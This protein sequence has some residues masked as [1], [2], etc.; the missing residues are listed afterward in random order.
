MDFDWINAHLGDDTSALRLK[1]G[2]EHA[3]DIL[4]I[5]MR[6]K[7][8]SKFSET[9]KN[10][11]RFIF[12]TSL[13]AEQ[14][15]SDLLALYHASLL[16]PGCT[17][18]DLTSGMGIDAMAFSGVAARVVAVE[19]DPVI[20]D[21]LRANARSLSNLTVVNDD[22]RNF[23]KS[24]CRF[25]VMFIDPARRNA[26]GGRV[27]ALADCEPD[28]VDLLPAVRQK[29]SSLIVK[30]SPM[31]D[32]T[33]SVGELAPY[34]ARVITLGTTTECKE[35]DLICDFNRSTANEP[36][37]QAVTLAPGFISE[38]S[39]Y[40]SR[41]AAAKARFGV[42][43]EGNFIFDPFPAVMK[44]APFRLLGEKFNLEKLGSN[45]HLWFAD[46][47]VEDFPGTVW[48]VV[49]VLP[50]MSKHIKRYASRF[51][52]VSVTARNFD[53]SSDALRSKLKVS[54]GPLRLF[55]VNAFD[56]RKL[57]ITCERYE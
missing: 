11:P 8:A 1:F 25:D 22:C 41:E 51:P 38:F 35:L 43:V 42:P 40:P 7:H 39:F 10:N 23:L 3:D 28:V 5:E 31:L 17:V 18:A 47:P 56:G 49:E 30:A 26:S 34:V 50:F 12:P 13:A 44:A 36:L 16:K 55:A 6:R 32:I 24:C 53:I 54:D 27:Y 4:Q 20:A 15:T 19:R 57:L 52:K 33:H 9:L 48:R 21:S 14:S 29:S 37:I 2:K 45:T 46:R